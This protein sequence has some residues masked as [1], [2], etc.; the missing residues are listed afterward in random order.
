[1]SQISKHQMGFG[2]MSPAA[3]KSFEH[4]ILASFAMRRDDLKVGI[5]V[6]NLSNGCILF[7]P[8]DTDWT[9]LNGIPGFC[10]KSWY[11]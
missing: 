5:G 2:L 7:F 8:F 4:S 11:C 3:R 1:M 9:G 6:F 10:G